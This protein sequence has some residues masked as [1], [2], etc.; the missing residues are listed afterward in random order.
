MK[1]RLVLTL[2]AA[3]VALGLT[4]GA[5]WANHRYTAS[6]TVPNGIA[7]NDVH[8]TFTGTGGAVTDIAATPDAGDG[9]PNT[10]GLSGGNTVDVVWDNKLD[11]SDPVTIS[12]DCPHGPIG[13]AGG[14]WTNDGVVYQSN[15]I[16]PANVTITVDEHPVPGASPL[17]MA[18]IALAVA[19]GGVFMI[20]RRVEA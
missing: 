1:S 20:R 2:L 17:V 11:P 14:T 15:L 13:V 18:L 6:L 3:T 8:I 9:N 4:A 19:A 12:F 7:P 16:T 5:A 10:A